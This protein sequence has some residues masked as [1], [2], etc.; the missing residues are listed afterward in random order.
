[1]T[2][3]IT[4]V[5]MQAFRGIGEPFTLDLGD[6]RS[7]VILGDNG[8]GKSS[9]ADAVEWYFTGRIEF[10]TREGRGGAIRHSGAADELD[11]KVTVTTGGPLEGAITESAP[12]S[13]MV[14]EIGRSELF[15]LRG[16][17]LADFID[18]TKGE[19]WQV[20]S[21]LLGLD[22]IDRLRLD[23]QTARNDLSGQVES[24]RLELAQREAAL[25]QWVGEVSEGS[26][27]EAIKAKCGAASIDE[28]LTLE[29]ALDPEWRETITS[30]GSGDR[31]AAALRTALDELLGA[32]A[33]ATSLD[34]IDAWNQFLAEGQRDQLPL[35]LYRA[36]DSL[37]GSGKAQDG[38]CPLCHQPFSLVALSERL[39][40]ELLHLGEEAR[41]LETAKQAARQFTTNLHNARSIRTRLVERLSQQGLTL[42]MPPEGHD[43]DLHRHIDESS[44]MERSPVEQ[45]CEELASWDIAASEAVESA[46]PR[47]DTERGQVL[48]DLGALLTSAEAWHLA[49]GEHEA[50]KAASNLADRL[51]RGYQERQVQSFT[52]I[53]GEISRRVAEI[54]DALHPEGGLGAVA[55]ETV[56]E[57]GAELA[58][59][60]HGRRELPPHRVLSESHLNSL[61]IALF[62]AMAETFNERLHFLIL[63]DVINS[64]DREHRGRLADLLVSSFS[65]RQLVV[66]T[67]DQQFFTR[68]RLLAPSWETHLL[69]LQ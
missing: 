28:P 14:R 25:H 65:D 55:I 38:I 64:F 16:R 29:G 61:G 57:K 66:L 58:V 2:E 63:D 21:E 23:L 44:P 56:G 22:A 33:T 67:H 8:T 36:A 19:K 51:F 35:T 20:L 31:R 3:R 48:V 34:P 43:E 15:L 6:G 24:A 50:K 46:I 12:S 53:I 30:E 27:L 7:C 5:E 52:Q 1:M 13:P 62:L 45:Y 18:K 47:P 37:I 11:T 68:L 39:K 17:T 26:I 59:E 49:V 42:P 10:L 32:A 69:V 9:I 40:S 4:A 60:F 54:Y 41:A